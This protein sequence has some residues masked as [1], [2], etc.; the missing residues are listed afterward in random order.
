MLNQ[1]RKYYQNQL[2]ESHMLTK[3]MQADLKN[4]NL[5]R[6]F[7]FLQNLDYNEDK[8]VGGGIIGAEKSL[9][10]GLR[11]AMGGLT[12]L[13][14][15]IFGRQDGSSHTSSEPD[16]DRLIDPRDPSR[17]M[18]LS[19]SSL[20]HIRFIREDSF[21]RRPTPIATKVSVVNIDMKLPM[22]PISDLSQD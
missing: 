2:E 3:S 6:T 18:N 11:T 15:E 13:E 17:M 9:G 4:L 10:G 1:S 12:M 8:A 20:N 22:P 16:D 5:R 21:E 7:S 19:I 14:N